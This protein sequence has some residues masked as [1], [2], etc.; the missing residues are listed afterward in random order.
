MLVVL[1]TASDSTPSSDHLGIKP[2]RV[3]ER[4]RPPLVE[5]SRW[6]LAALLAL[7][8][9]PVAYVVT[10]CVLLLGLIV[11]LD[12]HTGTMIELSPL[13]FLPIIVASLRFH[14]AGG[15]AVAAVSALLATWFS[16]EAMSKFD[17]FSAFV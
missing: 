8:S 3:G 13:Y 6:P 15:V 7:S 17:N 2:R 1:D 14:G 9:L 16:P 4:T 10:I 12:L 5:A 11:L